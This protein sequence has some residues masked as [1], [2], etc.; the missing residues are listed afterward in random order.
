MGYKAEMHTLIHTEGKSSIACLF[1][2]SARKLDNLEE[3]H[4]HMNSDS[5]VSSG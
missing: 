4:A 2:D 1:L 3:T 5:N